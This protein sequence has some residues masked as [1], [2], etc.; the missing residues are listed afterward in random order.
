MAKRAAPIDRDVERRRAAPPMFRAAD[1]TQEWAEN[2]WW[3]LTPAQS[4]PDLIAP[5]RLWRDLAQHQGGAFLSP[6]LGLA[7]GSFA[8][9]M[10]ALA[11]ID[12][13]FVAGAHAIAADGPRLTIA[14]AANALAGTSQIV[15][16]ELVSG[17][18]PLVVGQSYVRADDRTRWVDGEQV[19]KY[20]EG[21]LSAGVV[22]T[23][24]VVIANPTSSRQ[25]VAALVQIPRGS[26]P[27]AG[28]RPTHTIDLLL[29]PYGTAG[30]EYSFY[31]PAPGTFTHFPVHVSRGG[32]IVAAVP[33]RSLEV[34]AGGAVADT[35]S[36]SHVSQHGS[37]DEVLAFV[38]R[39]NL[40]ETDLDRIAW[41]MKDRAAY[42]AILGL[43]DRRRAY[44]ATLYGYA[45]LHRDQPR[46]R[47]F[48]RTLGSQLMQAGPVLDMLGLDAEDVGAYEHLELAPLVNARAHRLGGK[49]RILNDGLAAQ[50]GRFL[51]LVAH[52]AAP[53]AEDLL[54]AASYLLAQDRHADA[55]AMLSRV[56]ADAVTQRMQLDYLTA[57]A[58]C[59]RGD[60]AAARTVAE[61]WKELAVDRWRRKFEA[62]NAMLAEVAGAAPTV[63]DPE[64][65]D[66]Q[67]ADLAANQ[68]A[69]ELAVDRD[70]VVVRAQHVAQLELRFFEMDVE[71]LFSRQPFVQSDVSRFSYIEPGHRQLIESPVEQRV[72]WPAA[73]R[74]KNVVVE[75]VGVGQRKAK[76]HYAN[77]LATTLAHQYGQV[78]VQKPDGAALPTTY[79]KVYARHQGGAV[80][81]YK[82]GYT[83]LRGW[84]DY[85]TLSTDELDRVERFAILVSSDAH[86]SSILE[87]PPP[88]R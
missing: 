87:A 5:N 30:H 86:G 66:Q 4:G 35:T 29:E 27:V 77:E 32:S 12:L 40:A 67:H 49:L 57:Y 58:A 81:F 56:K 9:M 68:P 44:S 48:L 8:E 24:V 38:E 18:P 33:G 88:A 42:D 43:L 53:T 72:A 17:G 51:D 52:R 16:G 79:V 22:Y 23:C 20:V 83:D 1:K 45:L 78:R 69:F 65:R 26:L 55:L 39:A 10:C 13:P 54:A 34:T 31:F 70:G 60:I 21:T 82:D 59:L 6:W 11:V 85:A 76:I 63:I 2:N 46:I 28:A 74:G 3:H 80:S 75:A 50:Y 7:T 62:L 64:H 71:L 25:R 19:D 36:W 14:A 61:K 15:D 37:L 41:R 73:L 84:F 47:S